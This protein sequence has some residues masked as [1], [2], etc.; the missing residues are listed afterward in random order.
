MPAPLAR[1]HGN[2]MRKRA[3][4]GLQPTGTIHLGNY[5]G[6]IK[7]WVALQ[8][9]YDCFFCIVDYH[10]ITIPYDPGEMQSRIFDAAV[11]NLAAG[12]NPDVSTIFVQSHVPEHTELTW[13]LNAITPM[14]WLG[15]MTQFK[16]K[17]AQFRDTVNVG[18]FDYPVLQAA[19]ILLYKAEVVPVGEDQVQHIELTRDICRKFN[20]TF[21][22]VFPEPEALLS[23]AARIMA[24]NDPARKMSKSI[25]GSY[26][27]LLDSPDEIRQKMMRAVTDAGP[28]PGEEMSPGTRNLFSLLKEFSAATT[29]QRFQ[30]EYDNGT[31]RYSELKSVLADDIAAGLTPLRDAAKELQAEPDT[32]KQI[33]LDGAERARELARDTMREVKEKMGLI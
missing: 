14:G 8:D 5:V 21:G 23:P 32:I 7:N 30:E 19:D 4:S 31:I 26:V 1:G 10:A 12:L 29:V 18:L 6:A 13:L 22:S 2:G 33:L 27:G 9:Q 25:P 15:R 3:F 24:L 28:T 16:E 20:G 11:V 17:S